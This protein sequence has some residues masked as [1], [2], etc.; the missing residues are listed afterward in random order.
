MKR[1]WLLFDV[2][3]L[4]WRAFHTRKGLSYK[5]KDTGVVYGFLSDIAHLMEIHATGNVAFCFDH[6]K[7]IRKEMYEEYKANREEKTPEELAEYVKVKKQINDLKKK[8]LP[9]LGF[10]NLFYQKGY[11]GDD[12]I[13]SAVA[14]LPKKDE[15]LI[16]STDQD[17]YQLLSKRVS[18][19]N[20]V[21]KVCI[22]AQSFYEE[23]GIKPEE[24]IKVMTLAGCSSDNI[25]GVIGIAEKTAIRY[26]SGGFPKGHRV[27]TMV[28]LAHMTGVLKQ[29][30]SLVRLPLKGCKT[31]KFREDR[32]SQ[33]AWRNL[34]TKLGMNS[35]AGRVPGLITG[36]GFKPK[37]FKGK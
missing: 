32:V 25:K 10:K 26:L 1:T 12:F 31:V 19:W 35:I 3:N 33:T 27:H 37:K 21:K 18:I 7:P 14:C 24:W 29:V 17:Y 6:G 9:R 36:F 15:A 34:A 16:V 13:A 8:H 23:K 4:C 5:G 2:S 22:T 28:K 11:E 30:H 20:P